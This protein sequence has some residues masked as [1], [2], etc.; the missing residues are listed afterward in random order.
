MD[1]V[2]TNK[3]EELLSIYDN[4]INDLIKTDIKG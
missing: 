2:R 3:N 1:F 4:C